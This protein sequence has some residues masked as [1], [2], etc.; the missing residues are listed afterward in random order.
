LVFHETLFLIFNVTNM[1]SITCIIYMPLLIGNKCYLKISRH[2]DYT[3]YIH[4][5]VYKMSVLI[6][7][8]PVALCE[9]KLLNKHLIQKVS[10]IYDSIQFIKGMMFFAFR[11]NTCRSAN[12]LNVIAMKD[13]IIFHTF[14]SRE[15]TVCH[16]GV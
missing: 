10:K 2:I 15:I 13:R 3:F 1:E 12:M 9:N 8:G 14:L 4:L 11:F 5:I 7:L 16:V 6:C